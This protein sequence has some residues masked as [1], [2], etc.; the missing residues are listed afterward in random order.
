MQPEDWRAPPENTLDSLREA[1]ERFDGIE[2]DV[3]ITAD[4]QLVIHHDRDVSVPRPHLEGRPVW[5]ESWTLEDLEGFGFVSFEALLDDPTVQRAWAEQGKMGCI[6]IKRPHPKAPSGGGYFGRQKHNQHIAKAMQLAERALDEREIPRMNTVFYAFH[7][8]M[9]ASAALSNTQRPWAAL[10]PYVPPYGTRTTQ[11][12]QAL[13]QY[14]TTPFKRLVKRHQRQGSSM[15]PCAVEYVQPGTKHLSL[16]RHVGLDGGAY[17]RL[18]RARRG[19]ATYVWPTRPELEHAMLRA[20][21]TGLTD[22]ADPNLT[23]LPSGHARW[24]LPGT[25]PLTEQEWETLGKA[26]RTNHRAVLKDLEAKAPTWSECDDD[27]KRRLITEWHT[28]W[29]WPTDVDS[30]LAKHDGATPP[31]SAPRLIGHRGCGKTAR[32]VLNPH[33]R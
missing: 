2:F 24:H 13:P 18:N 14:I 11:R 27:R 6:E 31:W 15:L 19:M 7:K 22:H 10:I 29:R 3:R 23:W 8:G 16:G 26:N 28:R 9:P 12:L 5:V 33:S 4:G 21:L 32:P 30:V 17:D 1:M 20:G 25:R